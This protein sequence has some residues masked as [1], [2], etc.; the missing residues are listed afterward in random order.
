M[1]GRHQR[2]VPV[3]VPGKAPGAARLG[4]RLP[5]P[6][7]HHRGTL[8]P[9]AHTP[10]MMVAGPRMQLG[11]LSGKLELT[12]PAP[13]K[14]CASL[15]RNTGRVG[16]AAGAVGLPMGHL[17]VR[18]KGR[19]TAQTAVLQGEPSVERVSSAHTS[20]GAGRTRLLGLL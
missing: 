18:R 5:R 3:G 7:P 17:L 2:R 10:V 11:A 6:A 4:Q 12:G 16:G 1:G 13:R 9:F 20:P 14:G 19:D 15:D 8:C